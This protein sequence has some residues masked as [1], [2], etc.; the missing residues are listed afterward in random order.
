M[1]SDNTIMLSFLKYIIEKN[2]H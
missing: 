1:N 2:S